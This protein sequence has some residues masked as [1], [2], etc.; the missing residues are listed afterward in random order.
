[1]YIFNVFF[2]KRYPLPISNN[3]VIIAGS[4]KFIKTKSIKKITTNLGKMWSPSKLVC[5]YILRNFTMETFV[6][7]TLLT[8][9]TNIHLL[10]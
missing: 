7:N 2:K 3:I 9:H 4:S 10:K 1:M 6:N 8:F 5:I